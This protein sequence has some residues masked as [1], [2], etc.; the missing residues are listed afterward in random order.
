MPNKLT[1]RQIAIIA[2]RY[3][4][5]HGGKHPSAYTPGEI[6]ELIDQSSLSDARFI[7]IIDHIETLLAPM[8][9]SVDELHSQ[10]PDWD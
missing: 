1:D 3:W 6:C 7:R 9:E 10:I 8:R 2:L 4:L 5:H